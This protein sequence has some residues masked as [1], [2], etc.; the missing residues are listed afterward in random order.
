MFVP[1]IRS[2]CDVERDGLAVGISEDDLLGAG[3]E[4]GSQNEK[5]VGILESD[6]AGLSIDGER[7]AALEATAANG[8][9]C[10]TRCGN[11]VGC[12]SAD[13]QWDCGKP[14]DGQGGVLRRAVTGS[15]R[16]E[17]LAILVDGKKVAAE[18]VDLGEELLR[19]E[20]TQPKSARMRVENI[21]SSLDARAGGSAGKERLIN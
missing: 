6:A 4:A 11:R 21:D 17:P 18:A 8:E 14:N 5:S 16:E 20:N 13:S 12:E 19:Q 1:L 10:A 2:N 15:D 9:T 7:G 3:V